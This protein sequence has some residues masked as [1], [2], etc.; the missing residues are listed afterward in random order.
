MAA[1]EVGLKAYLKGFTF[2]WL[3]SM[4]GPLTVPFAILALFVSNTAYRIAFGCLAGLCAILTP[5]WVW[6]TERVALI[7]A[8]RRIAEL[9]AKQPSVVLLY[10]PD[11]TELVQIVNRGA[12][13]AF[14]V[15]VKEI[16]FKGPTNTDPHWG[17]VFCSAYFP[18]IAPGAK[19][20]LDNSFLIYQSAS[21]SG[22]WCNLKELLKFVYEKKSQD[23]S[24]GNDQCLKVIS[25]AT[26]N[27]SQRCV[28]E[29]SSEFTYDGLC[30][31]GAFIEN[32]KLACT[33]KDNNLVQR[34]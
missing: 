29:T 31:K 32:K 25:S 15:A 33:L 22:L 26:Y 3:T 23:G 11:R 16:T 19:F 10:D 5:Y 30:A 9:E 14:N 6:R 27:D 13:D 34:R 18:L 24:L 17:A 28:F 8:R 4:S 12:V 7:A 21:S 2:N 20:A 1:S